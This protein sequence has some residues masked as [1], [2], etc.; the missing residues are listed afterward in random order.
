MEKEDGGRLKSRRL[1]VSVLNR[2]RHSSIS[3][4]NVAE[5]GMT[6]KELVDEIEAQRSL[7]IAVA[8]AGP[9]IQT[10]NNEYVARHQLIA[11]ELAARHLPDPNP[12]TD[13]WAWYGKWSSGDL[14][15]YQSRRGYISELLAPL[16]NRIKA[17]AH[18]LV[19][20]SL[21]VEPTGWTKVDRQLG[22]V[23]RWLEEAST[24]E[25]FQVV[26]TLCR[27]VLISV[28]DE[29]YDPA[30]HPT[31]DGTKPS[32]TDFKR[33]IEAYIA[34]EM[35][36]A[37]NEAARRFARSSLDL[38]NDLQ[39]DRTAVFRQACLCAEATASVVNSLTIM[40]GRRDP[41]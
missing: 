12:Y 5:E 36:G 6:D 37:A 4:T 7:L 26:G 1:V 30:A 29:V 33:K 21:S 10:V 22:E 2:R 15:T 8:T 34:K 39:H 38:A 20:S 17:G 32:S 35:G 19:A 9:R 28:A 24:E 27:E 23:R 41:H 16:I 40:S 14:P 18:P 11:G 13:L 3:F 31:L 25:Q